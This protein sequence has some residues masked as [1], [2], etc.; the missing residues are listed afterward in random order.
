MFAC[1]FF[2]G[3]FFILVLTKADPVIDIVYFNQNV[4]IHKD[5][6]ATLGYPGEGPQTINYGHPAEGHEK[7]QYVW[8]DYRRMNYWFP[9]PLACSFCGLEFRQNTCANWCGKCQN[10]YH[11]D[12]YFEHVNGEMEDCDGDKSLG[13]HD[14]DKEWCEGSGKRLL[15]MEEP[16]EYMEN[17]R[18]QVSISGKLIVV[19]LVS[20]IFFGWLV[21]GTKAMLSTT[22]SF[23]SISSNSHG[24]LEN[25][26]RFTEMMCVECGHVV[27]PHQEGFFCEVHQCWF[28]VIPYRRHLRTWPCPPIATP[29]SSEDG[30]EELFE[31][32]EDLNE[33]VSWYLFPQ[34]CLLCGHRVWIHGYYDIYM[35]CGDC[36]NYF[37][38]ACFTRH[39]RQ[40]PCPDPRRQQG[41]STSSSSIKLLCFLA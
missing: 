35:E 10:Y 30:E 36:G 3:C 29:T 34:I 24:E 23:T 41:T 5:F 19:A 20:L 40:W 13:W 25:S 28:H 39:R 12:C 18:W 9:Y 17:K 21:S 14:I 38:N 16:P 8:D 7:G 33:W 27:G 2:V 31:E 26:T 6:D 1:G 32:P 22:S 37:H 15:V 11:N 4:G